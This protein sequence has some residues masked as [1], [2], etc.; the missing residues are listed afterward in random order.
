M[1]YVFGLI[2][3]LTAGNMLKSEGEHSDIGENVVVRLARK[4][5]HTTDLYDGDKLFTVV[6]GRRAMTPML[7]VMVAI[8]GIA[9]EAQSI[10][11]R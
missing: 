3:L 4:I 5:I 10:L 1:F 2:L 11:N 7:L 8:A 9:A 6:D